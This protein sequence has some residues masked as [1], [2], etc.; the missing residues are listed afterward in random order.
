M[1]AHILLCSVV[2]SL[3]SMY[4]STARDFVVPKLP[5]LLEAMGSA[6]LDFSI[7]CQVLYFKRKN[8]D[9]PEAAA[10]VPGAGLAIL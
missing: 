10:L 7:V 2:T 8:K 3:M 9:R 1:L 5:W 4:R 6:I